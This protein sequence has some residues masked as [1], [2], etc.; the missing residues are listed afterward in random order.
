MC[1]FLY[2]CMWVCRKK[3]SLIFIPKWNIIGSKKIIISKFEKKHLEVK[4]VFLFAPNRPSIG[5]LQLKRG[6]CFV[7]DPYPQFQD[8]RLSNDRE[9]RFVCWHL[10]STLFLWKS[11]R[12]GRDGHHHHPLCCSTR[13]EGY[14]T[15]L[16][17]GMKFMYFLLL[18]CTL[19]EKIYGRQ[20]F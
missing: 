16:C 11:S 12:R 14:T 1:V 6:W 20:S 18:Y 19:T 17:C 9:R 4:V 7:G 13:M 3:N 5:Q 8:W 2:I 10:N 15:R